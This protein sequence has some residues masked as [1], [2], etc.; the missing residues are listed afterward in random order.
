MIFQCYFEFK[1]A[2]SKKDTTSQEDHL[3]PRA[4]PHISE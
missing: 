4:N 2:V 1:M 3:F